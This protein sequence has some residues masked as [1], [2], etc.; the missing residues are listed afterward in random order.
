M[1]INFRDIAYT[2]LYIYYRVYIYSMIY[3]RRYDMQY[4]ITINYGKWLEILRKKILEIGKFRANI[5]VMSDKI[6]L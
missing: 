6:I 1:L 3:I 5:S 2:M 4:K